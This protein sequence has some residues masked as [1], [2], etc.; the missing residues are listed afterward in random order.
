MTLTGVSGLP[1][2]KDAAGFDWV[3]GKARIQLALAGTGAT[4]RAVMESLNGKADFVF[5]D[6]AII[7]YNV[8]QMIRGLSQ[9]KIGGFGRNLAEKTEFSEAGASFVITKGVAETK[10]LRALS[11]IV[12]VSGAGT[13]N[14]GQR[15]IDM[16][17]RPKL[18][19]A[20]PAQPGGIASGDLSGLELPIK[21]KGS[22]ERPQVAPD[23]DGLLKN[24]TQAV[25][26][27]R[28]IG[29]Q[30]QQGKTG[31]LNNLLEQFRRK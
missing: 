19:G 13:V 25:D 11:S 5:A 23:V 10:D 18:G 20:S 30:L 16:I 8:P 3:D 15:Q 7:G 6:G 31:G 24:P 21:I 1:V 14:L 2:L 29:R 9:G 27:I 28:E 26:T 22:W 17:V 12:R 4:E